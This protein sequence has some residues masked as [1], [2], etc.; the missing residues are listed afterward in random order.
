MAC[1]SV[2]LSS[3]NVENVSTADRCY[4]TG[5]G[6]PPGGYSASSSPDGFYS[7]LKTTSSLPGEVVRNSRIIPTCDGITP[8]STTYAS[9]RQ[10]PSTEHSW[11]PPTNSYYTVAA[12]GY[13]V[14][15]GSRPQTTWPT[16]TWPEIPTDDVKPTSFVLSAPPNECNA[17]CG[18]IYCTKRL[19]SLCFQCS[20]VYVVYE[21]VLF[22]L[23]LL[24]YWFFF[25]LFSS[26]QLA[27]YYRHVLPQKCSSVAPLKCMYVNINIVIVSYG[28]L[29]FVDCVIL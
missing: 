5:S 23:I 4:K 2:N 19:D 18:Q 25:Y 17:N 6:I 15:T 1:N 21:T 26:I 7:E 20:C 29:V 24:I 9:E 11:Y 14:H 3:S 12:T 13:P 22:L 8:S 10:C 27:L 16:V 28:I